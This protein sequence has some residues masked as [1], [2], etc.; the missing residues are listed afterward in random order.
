M[1]GETCSADTYSSS[2]SATSSSFSSASTGDSQTCEA[3]P[4]AS[5]P[6]DID[7]IILNAIANTRQRSYRLAGGRFTPEAVTPGTRAISLC[8]VDAGAP[9]QRQLEVVGER[10]GATAVTR[11]RV[12]V[13]PLAAH[14]SSHVLVTVD[15]P[16]QADLVRRCPSDTNFDFEVY[17]AGSDSALGSL[18]ERFFTLHLDPA[19]YRIS[20]DSCGI[21]NS[22][23][24]VGSGH[25][26]VL[27]YPYDQYTLTLTVPPIG[28]RSYARSRSTTATGTTRTAT[29]RTGAGGTARSESTTTERDGTVTRERSST[30]EGY[31]VSRRDSSTPLGDGSTLDVSTLE[32]EAA[33]PDSPTLELKKN[34]AAEDVTA[35]ITAIIRTLSSVERAV[36]AIR[37]LMR[38]FVPQVGFRFEASISFMQGSLS[39]T[40]GWKE[41]TDHQVYFG[42]AASISMWIFKIGLTLSFGISAGPATIRVLGEINDAGLNVTTTWDLRRPGRPVLPP[43]ARGLLTIP[44]EVRGE[45]VLDMYVTRLSAAAGVRSGFNV[46]GGS[47]LSSS[48]NV[49]M[50]ATITWTGLDAFVRTEAPGEGTSEDVYHIIDQSEIYSGTVPI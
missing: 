36:A 15:R 31:T 7:D 18:F 9:R 34:G 28:R 27:V 39:M 49:E 44:L 48:L 41:H 12:M 10:R 42:W 6:C 3:P 24:P 25:L 35:N 29:E 33:D 22:G 1:A 47:R 30:S 2:D 21:R 16:G 5:R 14:D 45:A 46:E 40:W 4:P 23:R 20:V 17:R 50:Y 19:R 13:H 32:A 26:D 38:N 8:G 37:E 11:I 43:T